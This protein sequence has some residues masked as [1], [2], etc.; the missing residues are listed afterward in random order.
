MR[1][2]SNVSE[3]LK[4]LS[5]PAARRAPLTSPPPSLPPPA[6]PLAALPPAPNPK[7]AIA[8]SVSHSHIDAGECTREIR[9]S[10]KPMFYAGFPHA[11]GPETA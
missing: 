4:T 7:R 3:N 8:H 2:C 1:S 9:K 5:R 11:M 6:R 10:R